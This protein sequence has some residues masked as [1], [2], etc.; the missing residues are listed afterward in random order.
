MFKFKQR[1]QLLIEVLKVVLC[2]THLPENVQKLRTRVLHCHT[3]NFVINW[4]VFEELHLVAPLVVDDKQ[5]ADADLVRDVVLM[6]R[7]ELE[8]RINH[9]L[10]CHDCREMERSTSLLEIEWSSRAHY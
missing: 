2:L 7:V 1:K 4:E 9:E 6:L 8:V 5:P 10:V 3:Q